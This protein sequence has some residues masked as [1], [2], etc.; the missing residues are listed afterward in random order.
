MIE[1]LKLVRDIMITL[2]A[3]HVT[4]A[5]WVVMD[6]EFVGYWLANA[7][8]GYY[9]IMDEYYADCDCTEAYPE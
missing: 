1:M 5:Y 7:E 4:V 2:A 6:A 3:A 8:I 9:S